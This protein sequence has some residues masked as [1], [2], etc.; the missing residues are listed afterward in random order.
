MNS[1]NY[2]SQNT[3]STTTFDFPIKELWFAL[4]AGLAFAALWVLKPIV[5]VALAAFGVCF[6]M[7]KHPQFGLYLMVGF[8]VFIGLGID[9]SNFVDSGSIL[10]VIDAPVVDYLGLALV[11]VA[12]MKLL[13]DYSTREKN[14]L[15]SSLYPLYYFGLFLLASILASLF[16][17][18][19]GFV[20]GSFHYTF[21]FIAF[22]FF[23]FVFVPMFFI[24]SREVL[25][26]VL[27]IWF[28]AGVVAAVFGFSSV[29]VYLTDWQR[30]IPYEIFGIAPLKYNHNV[31]AEALVTVVPVGA[32]LA[33]TFRQKRTFYT[34]ATGFVAVIAML[35]L[36]R[37]A[38]VALALQA[39]VAGYIFWDDIKHIYQEHKSKLYAAGGFLAPV[40]VY[41][42]WFLTTHIVDSS[43][44]A[45][46]RVLD[47][48]W[49]YFLEQPWLGYG[50]GTFVEILDGVKAYTMEFGQPLEAHGFV[51]KILLEQGAVGLVAFSIFLLWVLYT[52]WTAKKRSSRRILMG[53]LLLSVLAAITFQLFNTSYYNSHMWL[54][55]GLAL[56]GVKIFKRDLLTS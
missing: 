49:Y 7:Y 1:P 42:L 5:L 21:R 50:P 2:L 30:V 55:I 11:V 34:I 22:S 41:M 8:G 3:S 48:S 43:N 33:Y 17:F 46:L 53:S 9:M 25:L 23:A 38:W 12:F 13:F 15:K 6:L 16:V 24:S 37:A 32:Y 20:N 39:V 35:T 10:S 45:R 27:N 40:A 26:E 56:A 28:L 18:D 51:H 4:I 36:S 14:S 44:A 52:L 29:F 47:V 31:L 19:P 54:P